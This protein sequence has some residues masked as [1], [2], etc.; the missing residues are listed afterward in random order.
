M[1]EEQ[2]TVA[3]V[4]DIS[5]LFDGKVFTD[6]RPGYSG[7]I[8]GAENLLG[9]MQSLRD[10]WGFDYLSSVTG[11][12]Y[13]P[14]E[15]MEVVYHLFRSI[16]GPALVLKVHIDL[17]RLCRSPAAQGLEGSVLRGRNQAV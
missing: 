17:G 15:K 4:P 2:I 3:Q 8:V 6:T 1:S 7:F 10:E 11:V 14:E 12:D 9:V 5:Q 16:G 13:L